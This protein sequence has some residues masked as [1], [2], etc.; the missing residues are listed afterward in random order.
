[1]RKLST[2]AGI[3]MVSIGVIFSSLS[4]ILLVDTQSVHQHPF[5]NLGGSITGRLLVTSNFFIFMPI[6]LVGIPVVINGL[7]E[8]FSER[9]M[10]IFDLLLISGYATFWLVNDLIHPD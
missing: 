5:G 4:W 10:I 9:S 7:Y 2:I 3:V 8:K 1:M 6:I